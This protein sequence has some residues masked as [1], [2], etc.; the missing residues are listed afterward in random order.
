MG[1]RR[2]PSP[3]RR[4]RSPRGPVRGPPRDVLMVV[5]DFPSRDYCMMIEVWLDSCW[6]LPFHF[7]IVVVILSRQREFSMMHLDFFVEPTESAFLPKLL[8]MLVRVLL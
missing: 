8:A 6:G 4:S 3:R 2:S 7:V 5:V 1:R